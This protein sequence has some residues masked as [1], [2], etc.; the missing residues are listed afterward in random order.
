MA[1]DREIGGLDAYARALAALEAFRAR[2][3]AGGTEE[4]ESFLAAHADLRDL[5]VPMLA[6]AG[7][8]TGV[9][10]AA[11]PAP[12]W[13]GLPD[14]GDDFGAYRIERCIGEGGMGSV[15]LARHRELGRSVALKLILPERLFGSAAKERFWRE[16]K[17]ASKLDHPNICPLYEVGE[18]AGIPF[19]AMRFVEG[20]TLAA[21]IVRAQTGGSGR[22]SLSAFVRM[23]EKTARALHYAHEHGVVHRDVKPANIL[24]AA[25][26]E[27][28]IVDFGLARDEEA[29]DQSLTMSGELLGT[30][31]YMS[32][33][34][35]VPRGR[36]LDRTTDVYSLGVTLYECATLRRPFH[37]T[38]IRE[39]CETILGSEPLRPS[40]LNPQVSRDL[41]IVVEKAIDK[42]RERRY[43]SAADFADDLH[44]LLAHEPIR[45]RRAGPVLRLRR[46]VQRNPRAATFLGVLLV[47]LVVITWLFVDRQRALEEFGVVAAGV[48]LD[49]AIAAETELYPAWPQ[50]I[51]K[52]QAWLDEH[53]APLIGRLDGLRATLARLR[54]RARPTVWNPEHPRA[55]EL[56]AKRVAAAYLERQIAAESDPG[57]RHEFTDQ[58]QR[59]LAT[60]ERLEAE[61]GAPRLTLADDAQQ[62]LLDTLT[63]LVERIGR[64]AE[65]RHGPYRRVQRLLAWAREVEARSID[66]HRAAWDDA[67]AAIGR[68][69]RYGGLELPP[70]LGLVPLGEN[71][72]SRLWEFWHVHSG[73]APAIDRA[74]G[75]LIMDGDTGLV[76]VLLPGGRFR[77]GAQKEDPD[78]ANY[79]A[80]AREDEQPVHD[81]PL[82]A[83]FVAKYEMSQGQWWRLSDGREPSEYKAGVTRRNQTFTLLHPVE[84]VSRE[85]C[86]QLLGWY[87]LALPTEA[88]W[89]YAC[90]GGKDTPW[91]TGSERESLRGKVNLADRSARTA[92][93]DWTAIDDW[94]DFDDGY[95]THAPVDSGAPN[96]FGLH[97]THGNVWEWCRDYYNNYDLETAPGDGLRQVLN[98][99]LW[100]L[101]GGSFDYGADHARSAFR[102]AYPKRAPNA[103]IGVRPARPIVR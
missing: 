36:R 4:P 47:A 100:V 34:Q 93:F 77:L 82:D 3:R 59:T 30:P 87:G 56:R 18:V 19:M 63:P 101:R 81:V 89:E 57:T 92:G 97:N 71:P 16:A 55:W 88:Q 20:E 10:V 13:S 40:R 98:H 84:N 86:E 35:I 12:A 45:A 60:I 68:S 28:I 27:P 29:A 95:A 17:A 78:A 25:D 91:W 50:R 23:I 41:D 94:P 62:F 11:A 46:W 26:G 99:G 61:V 42:D 70:Q 64:F 31:L 76:F 5:L 66:D 39:L 67:R 54:G 15:Y 22:T 48:R 72:Q 32:P 43:R 58:L 24:V 75:R 102:V 103:T 21:L 49:A 52:M 69:P 85:D 2:Q 37:G 1:G 14:A 65:D 96:P 51:P 90:R 7:P 53:A 33:E 6:A 80:L 74:T 73:T 79:S 9:E 8:A 38:S 44:R 83:F